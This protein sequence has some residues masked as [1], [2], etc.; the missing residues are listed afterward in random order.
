[1]TT[2]FKKKKIKRRRPGS[3]PKNYFT[4]DT[5]AAIKEWQQLTEAEATEKEAIYAARI[6]PAFDALVTNLMWVYNFKIPRESPD[7]VKQDCIAFLYEKIDRW[8]PERGVP[9]FSYYNITAKRWLINRSKKALKENNRQIGIND[10]SEMSPWDWRQVEEYYV[11][12]DPSEI[13]SADDTKVIFSRLLEEL[14][15]CSKNAI[16]AKV[17][18]GIRYLFENMDAIDIV[19]KRSI[20]IYLREITGLTSIEVSAGLHTLRKRYRNLTDGRGIFANEF[21]ED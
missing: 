1:M 12:E 10:K 13:I 5:D 15:E 20:L 2:T 11:S 19:N 4:P 21:W 8:D 3:S 6:A 9:A 7:A 17:A 14:D 18:E 16:D